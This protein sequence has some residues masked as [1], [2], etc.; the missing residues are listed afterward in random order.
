MQSKSKDYRFKTKIGME[1]DQKAAWIIRTGYTIT[2]ELVQLSSL[3]FN[4]LYNRFEE[5][6]PTSLP[7]WQEFNL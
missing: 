6:C 3:F 4:R 7:R 5:I 2:R 1:N